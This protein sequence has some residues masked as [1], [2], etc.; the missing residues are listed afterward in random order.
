MRIDES[1]YRYISYQN[2]QNQSKVTELPKKTSASVEVK[3]SSRGREM[4]QAMMSEQAQ[5]QQR[6]QELKQQIANGTYKVDSSK[7]A[8]KMLDFWNKN[9]E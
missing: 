9:E 1:K 5:R 8:D 2:Q 7:V 3:I 4:S 6:V